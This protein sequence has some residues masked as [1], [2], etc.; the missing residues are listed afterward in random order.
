MTDNQ[1]NDY[2][3]M[4]HSARKENYRKILIIGN[5]GFIILKNCNI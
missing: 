3:V 1:V 4:P 2:I 5:T